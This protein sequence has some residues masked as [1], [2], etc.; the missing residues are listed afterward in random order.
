MSNARLFFCLAALVVLTVGSGPSAPARTPSPSTMRPVAPVSGRGYTLTPPPGWSASEINADLVGLTLGSKKQ[1]PPTIYIIAERLK[2][3]PT[4][5]SATA[6]LLKQTGASQTFRASPP[7][8]V[9]VDGVPGSVF[10][11]PR[12]MGSRGQLEQVSYV[13]VVRGGIVYTLVYFALAAD[14]AAHS[15]DFDAILRSVRW[16]DKNLAEEVPSVASLIG[17]MTNQVYS[18]QPSPDGRAVATLAYHDGLTYGYEFLSLR[19]RAGWRSLRPDDPIPADEVAEMADEGINRVTWAGPHTLI[20][21]YDPS[22]PK[23]CFV[24]R[25]TSWRGVRL[26]WKADAGR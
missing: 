25:G 7:S 10:T 24:K 20:V 15:A 2:K 12:E 9:T 8:A 1:D 4:L 5:K 13:T 19:P 17:H 21:W 26:V 22:T 16:N 18:E 14:F 23:D 11:C 6:A 3:A